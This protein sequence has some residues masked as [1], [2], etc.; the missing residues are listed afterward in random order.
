MYN[1]AIRM[2]S[3]VRSSGM[4]LGFGLLACA[5]V[6]VLVPEVNAATTGSPHPETSLMGVKIYERA[7]VVSKKFGNPTRI[8][9][10]TVTPATTTGAPSIAAITT[11]ALPPLPTPGAPPAE[12][13]GAAPQATPSAAAPAEASQV[14]WEY[15]GK[16]NT[17]VDFTLSGDGRVIQIYVS[18]LKANNVVTS[19]GVTLGTPYTAVLAK[20]GYP[21]SQ[22]SAGPILTMRY[23]EKSHVAFQL[24]NNK[25]VSITVAAVE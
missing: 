11:G 19:R 22:D 10:G 1:F 7:T 14:V 13:G 20:Y 17:T 8:Q 2:Y 25:V 18:G 12:L 3:T 9:T 5:A 4:R 16:N 23:T 6:L 21:E 15:A 24:Y